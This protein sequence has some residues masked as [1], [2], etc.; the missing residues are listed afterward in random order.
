MQRAA[1]P[2]TTGN[3]PTGKWP[4]PSERK[5]ERSLIQSFFFSI[6]Q[7]NILSL[8]G[9]PIATNVPSFLADGTVE[10]GAPIVSLEKALDVAVHHSRT[11][12]GRK[13]QVYFQALDLTL[14]RHQLTPLFSARGS[15]EY[16]V[17]TVQAIEPRVDPIT[18]QLVP[19]FSDNLVER[20]SI[21][22]NGDVNASW[23]IRDVGRIT[24]AFTTD[25]FR[26]L[27]GDPGTITSSQVGATFLRPLWRNAN[28]KAEMESLTLAER[29]LLYSLRDF[30]RFRK[31]FSVDIAALYYRVLQSRDAA[32]NTYTGFQSFRRSAERTR[33]LVKE[34]R[35]KMAEL[36]RL[37]QQELSQETLWIAAVRNYKLI[38]GHF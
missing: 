4:G 38:A 8:V 2:P 5:A 16:D 31:Q 34:G 17:S 15:G 13:E 9:L 6:E 22:A 7:T 26:F 32:Q 10:K 14:A 24:T 35:V 1:R 11:Y 18:G 30:T 28:F 37:E 20:N 25:F 36:G 23:L 21:R 27:R 3:Q 29:N 12:Q 19:V 33:A